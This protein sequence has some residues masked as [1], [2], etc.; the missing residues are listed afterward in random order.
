M[1]EIASLIQQHGPW[2]A[3]GALAVYLVLRGE[4]SFRYPRRR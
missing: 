3:V 4:F 2:V 1:A